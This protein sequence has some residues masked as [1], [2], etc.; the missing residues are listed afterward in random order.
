MGGSRRAKTLILKCEDQVVTIRAPTRI[1]ITTFLGNRSDERGLVTFPV[2]NVKL[3]PA[4]VPL[5]CV[6]NE[7]VES[8]PIE[9]GHEMVL[10]FHRD[11]TM[12]GETIEQVYRIRVAVLNV[13]HADLIRLK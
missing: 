1:A 12:A 5:G 10:K 6:E 7:Q 9:V 13:E 2:V 4:I 3:A 11:E 8:I